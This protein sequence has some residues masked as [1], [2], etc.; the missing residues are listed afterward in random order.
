MQAE[1]DT[2]YY[3][4]TMLDDTVKF[5]DVFEEELYN[6]SRTGFVRKAILGKQHPFMS[7]HKKFKDPYFS[8]PPSK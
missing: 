7:S 3:L 1:G 2:V 8:I 4:I 5:E 6:N